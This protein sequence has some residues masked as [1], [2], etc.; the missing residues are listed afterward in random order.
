MRAVDLCCGS[1]IIS[2]LL[3]LRNP[4]LSITG[5]EIQPVAAELASR[6]AGLSDVADRVSVLNADVRH[7]K[8]LF[9]AGEFDLTVSNPPYFVEGTGIKPTNETAC[10]ARTEDLCTL[11]DLCSAASYLTRWGGSFTLVH[12]PDR[13]VDIFNELVKFGFQPKRM[14]F[15]HHNIKS[16][17]CLVLI[18]SRRGG[19]PSL[20]VESPLILTN[21]DGSRTEEYKSIYREGNQL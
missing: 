17:P 20:T 14:R 1:G 6:N 5:V 8:E 12:R 10:A 18:D 4:R 9:K 3:A 21:E 19:K 16:L 2:V 15:V 13:L 11:E 7:Y